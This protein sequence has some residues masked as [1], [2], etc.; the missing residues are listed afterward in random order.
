M[1]SEVN[2]IKKI[3]KRIEILPAIAKSIAVLLSY[4]LGSFL[5]FHIHEK[6]AYIGAML[7]CTSAIVVLQ[8]EDL[9][10]SFR[11]AWLRVVGTFI[12][13]VMAIC[14]LL[15]FPFSVVGM[16]VAVFVLDLICMMLGVPDNGKMAAITLV[17]I[18]IVSMYSTNLSPI[19]NGTLRFLESAIGTSIGL[20]MVWLLRYVDE[21]RISKWRK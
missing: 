4:W 11:I 2:L 20:L 15:L 17:I 21:H 9:K 7:A 16:V 5:T 6:T 19:L 3:L 18:L 12:G 10:G 13:A 8:K 14:Y 1:D